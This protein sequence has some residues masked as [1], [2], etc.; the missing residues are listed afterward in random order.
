MVAGRYR[1][2]L[3][4]NKPGREDDRGTRIDAGHSWNIVLHVWLQGS[5]ELPCVFTNM[6]LK[7]ERQERVEVGHRTSS[8]SS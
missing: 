4:L 1:T 5:V 7:I 6:D 8:L 2:A 3:R